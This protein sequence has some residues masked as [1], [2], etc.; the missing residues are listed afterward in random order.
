MSE[1]VIKEL[2]EIE[3]EQSFEE[4][5]ALR[6]VA[7]DQVKKQRGPTEVCP[8]LSIRLKVSLNS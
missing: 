5:A 2:R 8:Q 6:K 4:L 7:M 1:E 3:K